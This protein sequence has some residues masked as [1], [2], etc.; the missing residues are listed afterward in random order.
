[1]L[2]VM[3]RTRGTRALG[4]RSPRLR[5]RHRLAGTAMTVAFFRSD[6]ASR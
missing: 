2:L 5:V 4:A 3:I 6:L 1:M